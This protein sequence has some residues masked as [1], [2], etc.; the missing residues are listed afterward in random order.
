MSSTEN[1]PQD[2]VA[3]RTTD[4]DR[5]LLHRDVLAIAIPIT[6]S[7]ATTP[8]VGFADTVVIGQVGE[9]HL[10]GG[11][12][13]ASLIFSVLYWSFSFLRMGTTGLTAQAVGARDGSEIAA[14]LW[15]PV[16]VGAIVGAVIVTF[17]VPIQSVALRTIGGSG[18][19]AAAASEYYGWRVWAAPA[20]LVNFALLGW[21]IG[22]GRAKLAFL[23]QLLLNGINIALAVTLG[24]AAGWGVQGVGIAALS[25]EIVAAA[26]GLYVARREL[27]RLGAHATLGQ[28]MT[29]AR[30]MRSFS[31]NRDIMIRSLSMFAVHIF[32]ASQGAASGDVTLAANAVLTNMGHVAIYLID[33]FAFAAETLVGQ[34]VGARRRRRFDEAVAYSTMWAAVFGAGLSV[35]LWLVGPVIIDIMTNS[36]E[37]RIAAR[38]YLP[39]A[40]LVPFVGVWCFQLDGI[41][42][43]ATRTADMRNMMILSILIFFAAWWLLRGYGNHGLWAAQTV[44]FVARGLTLLTRYPSL[45]HHTFPDAGPPKQV[46]AGVSGGAPG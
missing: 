45:L 29:P 42:I 43:G 14:N 34:A 8:L 10:I 16:I 24:L 15:R 5:P 27:S 4:F 38:T 44:L 32:F 23:I 26:V 11:V 7:N 46:P 12:A 13:V 33:G 25:A 40:A 41:F 28:V 3:L 6:I 17:Q 21:F 22:L 9:P 1:G 37:V 19:V 31:V 18:G 2:G 35:C 20:G 36:A 30:L 39:W